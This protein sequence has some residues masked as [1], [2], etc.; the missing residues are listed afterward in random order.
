MGKPVFA[1]CEQQSRRSACASPQSDQ[2]LCFRFL[3]SIIPLLAI[4][5]ISSFYLISVLKQASLSLT[6]SQT[7]KTAFLVTRLISRDPIFTAAVKCIRNWYLRARMLT[8]Q[9][10]IFTCGETLNSGQLI[11]KYVFSKT[12]HYNHQS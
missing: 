9:L 11:F 5:E 4:P 8:L 2:H 12:F 1:T 3:D 10:E 6:W 7:Q